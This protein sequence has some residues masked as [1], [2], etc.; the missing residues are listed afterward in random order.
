[1]TAVEE[2]AH[3]LSQMAVIEMVHLHR[4]GRGIS[5]SR[6]SL[7]NDQPRWCLQKL[8]NLRILAR[9][10]PMML[11]RGPRFAEVFDA[12]KSLG[13]IALDQRVES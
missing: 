8:L 13:R 9:G 2:V 7:G 6:D 4:T 11:T 1:M 5:Y 12:L 10:G 3:N